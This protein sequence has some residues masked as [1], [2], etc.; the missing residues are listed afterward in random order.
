MGTSIEKIY[1]LKLSEI[2]KDFF[3]RCD[4]DYFVNRDAFLLALK[5]IKLRKMQGILKFLE[6]GK[7][8]EQK[9]YAP[10]ETNFIHL[11][12]RDV[13]EGEIDLREP[14]FLTEEKG[15]ELKE[16]RVKK[17]DILM[18]ISSNVGDSVLFDL[19]DEV[20]YTMSH[21]MVRMQIDE[22]QYMPEF[23]VYYLN[24]PCARLFFRAV[25]TGKTQQNLSKTY[26]YNML[27]PDISREKQKE[28]MISILEVEEK[29]K[30]YKEALVQMTEKS[31]RVFWGCL[32]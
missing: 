3:V 7:P 9:D 31:H 1:N 25:E 18:V 13:K 27:I 21:Y 19:D 17:G 30:E 4:Y 6:T 32:R 20:Q 8:I 28:I 2:S 10:S 11:V 23:L 14:I 24:H 5:G 26:I 16:Y 15:E 22:A 29:K 12:P